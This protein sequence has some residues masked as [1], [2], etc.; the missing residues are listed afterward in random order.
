MQNGTPNGRGHS[1]DISTPEHDSGLQRIARPSTPTDTPSQQPQSDSLPEDTKDSSNGIAKHEQLNELNGP[2]SKR[3]KL[4]GTLGRSTPRPP[5]PPWKRAGF[6]GPTSFMEDGKRRSTRTNM[7]PIEMLPEGDPRRTQSPVQK[8]LV[9]KTIQGWSQGRGGSASPLGGARP[10]IN[11]RRVLGGSNSNN[12]A[13]PASSPNGAS[14]RATISKAASGFAKSVS[15]PQPL[16]QRRVSDNPRSSHAVDPNSPSD[17]PVKRKPGRPRR[18]QSDGTAIV[19]QENGGHQGWSR[20]EARD[21]D[22]GTNQKLPR[23][24]FRVKIPSLEIQHPSHVLPPKQYSSFYEWLYKTT[25]GDEDIHFSTPQEALQEAR[26]RLRLQEAGEPNQVLSKERCSFYLTDPEE[27]APRQYSHQDHFVAHALY[28]KKLLD[29]ERKHHRNLARL[30]AHWC[31]DAWKKRNKAPEDILKEQH[32]ELRQ[33]RRQLIKDLQRQFDLVRAEVDKARLAIWEQERKMEEQLALNNAL[34]KS[35]ALFER[36]RSDRIGTGELEDDDEDDEGDETDEGGETTSSDTGDSVDDSNMSSSGSETESDEGLDGNDDEQLSPEALRAK[37]AN[38]AAMDVSIVSG[39]SSGE[40]EDEDEEDEDE[41]EDEDQDEDRETV[42]GGD[43]DVK[44]LLKDKISLAGE[45]DLNFVKLEEVDPLLLDESD[46]STDM[47]DDMGDSDEGDEDQYADDANDSEESDESD[48]GGGGLLGFFSKAETTIPNGDRAFEGSNNTTQ[49]AENPAVNGIHEVKED[50]GISDKQAH[51]TPKC[52]ETKS[53]NEDTPMLDGDSGEATSLAPDANDETAEN[54]TLTEVTSLGNQQI[55]TSRAGSPKATSVDETASAVEKTGIK[56]PI[57]H[58]LRGKL[59]EYQHFGLDWLAG[60]YASNINGILA[61]EMGLGKTIQTIALLAHLAV[62]H[63]VWG[64]HLV[65]VPTSVMLN[66]E[67]EFKKWCPGFKILTYYG[68]QEERRQKRKGWMDDDRWHVCITSYQLVLQ[69]QQ[70][71]RRR[72]WHY[73]VLD[74]A[75]NI[76]NF[77]SQR[78]QTLLTFKTQARLLLTGTPLQNNLT[79]LWSLLFFLMPSDEDGNGIEG[80]ADLRNFSEWFRRPVEQILEHGR[81]TMDD[82]AKAVVSKL[83]T[84]LRPYILRRLKVDVEKQMPAKYEHVVACRLSKRQRYL[85]DGFMSR[86]QTKETLASGNYLSIINCLMQLRKVC[87]HPDLFE[88]RPISTSFAMPSSVV[89]DFEIKDLLVRRRLLKE[90]IL[91]K[92][93]LDFLNLA[94]ISREQ[95]SKILVEDCARIMAYNPLNSLRQRQ[96]NR[97]NWDMNFDGSTVR[98]TLRSMDNNARKSRMRELERCLYFESKRH[99]QRPV[100]GQSLIDQLTIITP[101]QQETRHRPPRKLLLDWLS[102]KSLVLASMIRSVESTSLVME[103]LVRKFACLTPAAVA[104]GVTAATLTPITSRYFTPSQR[105]P[106]YD[107]FHEAQVRLSIAFPDKRLLQYDCGK[108]QQLDKLLRTLQAGGHRALIFT[109][110]TKMLDILEQ[111]LNIHGHR[112]LR[113]DGST[114]IEQRQLLTER[115]N[116]DTRILAFILSSRSGGL[117]INLTGADTV[118]FYD[119]DWNPAMDKQCQDRCHRIGQTRDVHIYRFVSEYTIESNILR[120]ANQKRML[121]DVVIQEG[122]F[123]TDYLNRLD[124]SGILGDEGLGEGHDEAGAAMDRVLDTKVHGTSSR[125]FEQAEDRE[126]IDAAKTAEKELEQ[127]V[128]DSNFDNVSTPQTPAAAQGQ[129][130]PTTQSLLGTPAPTEAGEYERS[131]SHANGNTYPVSISVT[132]DDRCPVE[133]DDSESHI[134]HIDD[135]LLRFMEWNLRDEPLVLPADKQ[136][137][138]SKRGREHRIRRK[139]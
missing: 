76:K 19:K 80:F 24:R 92:L 18:R 69:D 86:T 27:I 52:P 5:S 49:D 39:E 137:K 95:G 11:G 120:K 89:S 60:L 29:K 113:L 73:M 88:T 7:I 58:L 25:P 130:H 8:G 100:Y 67:M 2:P 118:I 50:A 122:E 68:T 125:I 115:F 84:I 20:S 75:H 16:S 131:V 116:N 10:E 34:K 35:T 82:E 66:W 114:K 64:P 32:N 54:P 47:D 4:G 21:G 71:F 31:A 83:H 106:A 77:R 33:K 107:P 43:D 22:D 17:P 44:E 13:D 46:E 51:R 87:N 59:R 139:R 74:E 105:I 41:D 15:Q 70:I 36:R 132:P 108:L 42:P 102:N 138:K 136:R 93:D 91:E 78:W 96:Y 133:G 104:Q 23:L 65:I 28:F 112:Y 90:N 123:T 56:T 57:P 62:E 12:G 101:L 111:F 61:D 129:Q 45:E 37:Y 38:L 98:S 109:Q 121:D 110:M 55:S 1:R 128:D 135:Y 94:P 26:T 14:R 79:E 134:G 126:D 3:R 72:N 99:G 103:P 85:Y 53:D 119:L 124:V 9:N 117:G 30:F 127:T 40:S 48:D 81:E 63:E 6:D 97:T